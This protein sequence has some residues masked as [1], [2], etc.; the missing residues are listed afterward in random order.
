[1]SSKT[2]MDEILL[3]VSLG[4]AIDKLTILD[5][6]LS[7]IQDHRRVDVQREYDILCIKLKPFVDTYGTLY[8]FMKKINLAIWDQMNAL[9]NKELRDDKRYEICL[10]CLESNDVRFRIKRKINLACKSALQ[11]QKS[12]NMSRLVIELQCED[13]AS[14]EH[15]IRYLSF[16]YD[17]VVI[18]SP[19]NVDR[20]KAAFEYDKTVMYNV[21]VTDLAVSRRVHAR[22]A[23]QLEDAM[24]IT[25][26]HLDF[27]RLDAD[28][29]ST[30]RP[31]WRPSLLS[32]PK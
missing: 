10:E 21:D 12:Y 14:F 23:R 32:A 26:E 20:L 3:P 18:Q 29:R 11:E 5:I 9:R 4:E 1:M 28:T 2:A 13:V 17:E 27:A 22:D 19:H 25:G 6:K 24:S 7:S 30:K 16:I 31:R 8:H 15:A